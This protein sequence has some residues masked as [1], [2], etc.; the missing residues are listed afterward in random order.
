MFSFTDLYR[1]RNDV[2]RSR[3]SEISRSVRESGG[4]PLREQDTT[5][6]VLAAREG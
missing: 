5:V 2:L 6:T 4:A 1:T 3:R